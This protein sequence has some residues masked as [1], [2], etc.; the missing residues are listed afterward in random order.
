VHFFSKVFEIPFADIVTYFILL[1]YVRAGPCTATF[2]I[3]CAFPSNSPFYHSCVIKSRI[4]VVNGSNVVVAWFQ[5]IN[6]TSDK[7]VGKQLPHNRKGCGWIILFSENRVWNG[8]HSSSW[9]QPRNCLNEKV[10]APVYNIEIMAVRDPP[11]PRATLLTAA[12]N[13]NGVASWVHVMWDRHP[14]DGRYVQGAFCT[15]SLHKSEVDP[16]WHFSD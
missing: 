3:Y 4:F 6:C 2:K 1:L 5:K 14:G 10:T 9:V 15:A 13:K 8:V 12:Q 7:I 16:C 11:L